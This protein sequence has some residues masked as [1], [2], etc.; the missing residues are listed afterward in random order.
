MKS[1]KAS[2]LVVNLQEIPEGTTVV[3]NSDELEYE[4]NN[5]LFQIASTVEIEN[6]DEDVMVYSVDFDEERTTV[7]PFIGKRYVNGSFEKEVFPIFPNIYRKKKNSLVA[8]SAD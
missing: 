1:I 8:I 7:K 2:D 6:D 5:K 4:N 3:I